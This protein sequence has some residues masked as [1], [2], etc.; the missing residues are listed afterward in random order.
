MRA[1]FDLHG[2][3]STGGG[4]AGAVEADRFTEVAVRRVAALP[5]ARCPGLSARHAPRRGRDQRF[6]VEG[7]VAQRAARGRGARE[8]ADAAGSARIGR[9]ASWRSMPSRCRALAED[10]GYVLTLEHDRVRLPLARALSRL[11]PVAPAARGFPRRSTVALR[12]RWHRGPAACGASSGTPAAVRSAAYSRRALL[13]GCRRSSRHIGHRVG[14]L[15]QRG[16]RRCGPARRP[17]A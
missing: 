17:A 2:V 13:C 1:A 10:L 12:R 6:R 5:D 3:R 11:A 7:D 14:V 15:R 8:P 9:R 16:P 4:S